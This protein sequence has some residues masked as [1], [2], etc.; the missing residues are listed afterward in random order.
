LHLSDEAK[1]LLG[2]GL[3]CRA[4]LDLLID[5]QHLTDAAKFLANALPKR[6]AVWW[7]CLCARAAYGPTPAANLAEAL[8]AA[9]KWAAD[10]S[11]ANRRAAEKAA[12]AAD[13]GTPAGC[14][15]VAA[16]WS[17]GSLGP[18][19]VHAIPPKEHLTAHGVASAVMLAVVAKEP[20]K[21]AEKYKQFLKVGIDVGDGQHR[22]D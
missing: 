4:Y 15:A 8:Q 1:A 5:K 22:W 7:A 13:Y 16:F 21:S 14:A 10:P 9:E 12:V 19:D 18:P 6:E 11:E 20:H 17:G 2:D 3:K